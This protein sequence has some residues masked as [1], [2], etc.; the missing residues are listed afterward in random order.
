MAWKATKE[1]QQISYP[2]DEASRNSL[3]VITSDGPGTGTLTQS[4]TVSSTPTNI[5]VP[6]AY[7]GSIILLT[8]DGAVTVPTI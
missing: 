8:E 7:T 1:V 3:G 6:K 2:L 4:V 5:T